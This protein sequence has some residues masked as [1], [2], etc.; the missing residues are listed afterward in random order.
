MKNKTKGV[1][2]VAG[3]ISTILGIVFAIPSFLQGNY[4]VAIISAILIVGGL[5]LLAI[6]FED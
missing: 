5:V 2:S 6:S 4:G 3:V 1:L